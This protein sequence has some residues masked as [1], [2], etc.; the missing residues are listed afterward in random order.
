MAE[1]QKLLPPVGPAAILCLGFMEPLGLS[2]NRLVL[3]LRAPVTRIAGL[4][5]KR[6]GITP[7]TALRLAPYFNTSPGLWLNLQSVHHLEIAQDKLSRVIDR[8]LGP[9]SRAAANVAS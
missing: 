1:T 6:R 8:E 3:D 4:V 7:D 5:H 9:A 2:V